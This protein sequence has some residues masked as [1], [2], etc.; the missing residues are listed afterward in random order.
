MRLL[1]K[2]CNIVGIAIESYS[3][4]HDTFDADEE[5]LFE[6]ASFFMPETSPIQRLR[7]L[8]TLK[9]L[10]EDNGQREA[11]DGSSCRI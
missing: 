10:H 2:E 3:T 5:S 1:G 4:Q 11:N 7:W 8:D 6:A 9:C